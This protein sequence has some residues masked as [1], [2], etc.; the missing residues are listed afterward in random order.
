MVFQGTFTVVGQHQHLD[1]FQQVFN[2]S[3][4]RQGVGGERFFKVDTQ[5]LLVAAH[6]PQFDDSRLMRNALEQSTNTR[7]FKPVGQAVGSFVV[8]GHAHQ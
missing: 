4:Q 5:Q 3:T 7:A 6:D 2:F 1:A 8:A